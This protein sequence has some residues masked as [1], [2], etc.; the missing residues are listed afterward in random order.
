MELYRPVLFVHVSAII[1][2]FAALAVEWVTLRFLRRATSY[3]QAR[4][5]M[6]VLSLLPAIGA[7]SLLAALAS[8]VYLA[9]SL[10]VW[11]LGWVGVAIPTLVSV[12]VAGGLTAPARNRMRN[13]LGTSIGALPS[14]VQMQLSQTLWRRSLRVRTA[15]LSGLVFEMTVR[16]DA[17]VWVMSAVAILGLAWSV[18]VRS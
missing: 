4:E 1:G 9:T 15:L 13:T 2:L 3:E 14:A 12:A 10:G 7:P 18:V 6:R 11:H 5:W 16:P 17:G 8:G